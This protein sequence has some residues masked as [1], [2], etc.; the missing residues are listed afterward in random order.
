LPDVFGNGREQVRQE[1]EAE[2]DSSTNRSAN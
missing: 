2:K 1:A